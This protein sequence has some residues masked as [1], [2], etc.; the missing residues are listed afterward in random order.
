MRIFALP[1]T[2]SAPPRFTVKSP[3]GYAKLKI[4]NGVNVRPLAEEG[5]GTDISRTN[6]KQKFAMTEIAQR[7]GNDGQ[8]GV[9]AHKHVDQ[10]LPHVKEN[11]LREDV[12]VMPTKAEAVT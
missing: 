8:A 11:V 3:A 12:K 6:E 5:R 1:S 4:Q 7:S 10:E 2:S 9:N